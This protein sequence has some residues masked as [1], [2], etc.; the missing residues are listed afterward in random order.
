MGHSGPG[1]RWAPRHSLQS[2]R[3][4]EFFPELPAENGVLFIWR[5]L[6]RTV[7]ITRFIAGASGFHEPIGTGSDDSP[8]AGI[9]NTNRLALF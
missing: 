4:Q 1:E 6:A 8:H 7:S 9:Q 2:D 3:P 5:R